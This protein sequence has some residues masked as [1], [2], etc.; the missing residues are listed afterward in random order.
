MRVSSLFV[1]CVASVL[2]ATTLARP[3]PPSP[4]AA[5]HGLPQ[6]QSQRALPLNGEFELS[7]EG[8]VSK[9]QPLMISINLLT[10]IKNIS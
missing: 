6:Q 4:Y 8:Y 7:S 5:Y 10:F 1:V 2:V 3:E 9:Y